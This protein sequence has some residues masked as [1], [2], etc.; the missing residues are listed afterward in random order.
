[1]LGYW[2]DPELT[3][4]VIDSG[5]WLHTGDLGYIRADGNLVL[6]GR[7]KEMYIRGGYNVYPV[8]IEAILT[9]HP[10]INRVAVI[11]V[12]DPVLGEIGVACL[13]TT[14]GLK[15]SLTEVQQWCTDRLADYKAP[16]RIMVLDELPLTPMLK[17]DKKNLAAHYQI[18]KETKP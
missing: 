17:I 13:V 18:D 15:I 7:K 5:G 14:P 9:E 1:M 10:A 4:S 6:V 11:G 2:K 16:D 8:E 3:G 12:D